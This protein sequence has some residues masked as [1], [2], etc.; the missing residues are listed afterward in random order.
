[1]DLIPSNGD[2]RILSHD[3]N[4]NFLL[5][6]LAR[7]IISFSKYWARYSNWKFTVIENLPSKWD[8]V[9][10]RQVDKTAD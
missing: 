1:M 8:K 2:I 10:V 7:F 6:N 4:G 5:S 3:I 9:S